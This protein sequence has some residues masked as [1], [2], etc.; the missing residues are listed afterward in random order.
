MRA[1]CAEVRNGLPLGGADDAPCLGGYQGL[2]VYLGEDRRLYQLRVDE[3]GHNRED[4]L[5]GVHDSTLRYSVDV[6]PETESPKELQKVLRE[7]SLLAEILYVLL[8]EVHVF[9]VLDDLLEPREYSE[10]ALVG[11]LTVEHVEGNPGVLAPVPE[12][13]I[14]HRHLVEIHNHRD[15]SPVKLSHVR[16]LFWRAAAL[17]SAQKSLWD[18]LPNIILHKRGK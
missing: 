17:D 15:V 6:P 7:Q 2:V 13:A 1:A 9:Y 5:V 16:L 10:A 8:G 4:R 3:I 18:A 11:V 12:V 14:C